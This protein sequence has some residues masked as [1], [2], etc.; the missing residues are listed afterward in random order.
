MTLH[1]GEQHGDVVIVDLITVAEELLQRQARR[2]DLLQND[3]LLR[4]AGKPTKL[5]DELS[6]S[7][8][9]T[10]TILVAGNAGTH[11]SPEQRLIVPM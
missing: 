6:Q 3:L 7:A 5:T 1:G 9:V 10:A 8:R 2:A 11:Q 4:T